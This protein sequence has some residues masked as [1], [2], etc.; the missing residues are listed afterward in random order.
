MLNPAAPGYW[1]GESSECVEI[2]MFGALDLISPRSVLNL[3]LDIRADIDAGF[4][5]RAGYAQSN[6]NAFG[7]YPQL[8]PKLGLIENFECDHQLN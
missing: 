7:Y 1:G 5:Y 8:L 6:S 2:L 4:W 3:A